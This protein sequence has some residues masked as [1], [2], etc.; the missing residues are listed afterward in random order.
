MCEIDNDIHTA[1]L[2]EQR[3]IRGLVEASLSPHALSHFSRGAIED[4]RLILYVRHPGIAQE[5]RLQKEQIKAHMRAAYRVQRCTIRFT[6]I[7][8][9]VLNQAPETKEPEKQVLF[10]EQAK[11]DFEIQ[12]SDPAIKKKFEEIRKI[13]KDRQ[14]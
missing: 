7:D 12:C 13:I 2:N 6:D 10:A 1:T 8:V 14:G 11:G 9:Q 5:I 4:G 3:E